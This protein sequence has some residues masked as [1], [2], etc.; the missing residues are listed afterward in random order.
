M[1]LCLLLFAGILSAQT[2]PVPDRPLAPLKGPYAVGVHEFLWID[3]NRAEPFTKDPAD[4][5]RVLARVWYPAEPVPGAAPAPYI[6]DPKEFGDAALYKLVAKV[7]TNSVT[8]APIAK[9]PARFP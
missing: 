9:K 4:R 8:D 1:R 5:R 7:K 3:Q 2:A 6:Y